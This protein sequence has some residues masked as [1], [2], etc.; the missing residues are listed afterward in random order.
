MS[1]IVN[2]LSISQLDDLCWQNFFFLLKISLVN[3]L[4]F[5][6]KRTKLK[7]GAQENKC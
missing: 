2:Q 4:L 3:L 7:K 5:K 1:I 6:L